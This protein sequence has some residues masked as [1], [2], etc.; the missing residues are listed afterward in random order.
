MSSK[1]SYKNIARVN[2]RRAKLVRKFRRHLSDLGF[3]RSKG[4]LS[5][6]GSGKDVI[7]GLHAEHRG[8]RIDASEQFIA[9][10]Y[11]KLKQYFASGADIDPKQ[12]KP[13]L[14]RIEADTWQSS[15]FRLASLTWSVPVS[16][17]FGRRMR[18]L[19]WDDH[20][21]KLIGLIA[22]GDPVFN[23]AVRDKLIGWTTKDRGKRLVNI[24]DAYVLGAIPPY[25]HLL[26]GKLV[27]SLVRT[28]EIYDDF[29]KAYGDTR[30]IIS[31][32]KKKARLLV[33]TT[34]SSLGRSSIYNRL[35]LG[36]QKYFT[37]IGFTGGWGHFHIPDG[38]F[39]E[40][41]AYLRDI[42]HSYADL[43]K[44]GEGPNWRLRTTRAALTALGYKE[45][46][47]RHGIQR[48]VYLCEMASNALKIL[49]TGNGRPNLTKLKTVEEV[50]TL[51]IHRWVVP[52]SERMPEYKTWSAADLKLLLSRKHPSLKAI[53]MK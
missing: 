15:L 53:S 5:F 28:R 27:A 42:G 24:L 2:L 8:D 45:D 16:N 30:G 35:K 50:S 19:V 46:I 9:E 33:V 13:R 22:I 14:E 7:R 6:E 20:N 11:D 29:A 43:H 26:G 44:Y 40:M 4:T 31:R 48:E 47:L 21:S 17:G 49:R 32:K 37:P 51:A 41:R 39:A 12:I 1:K 18:Y 3:Q 34:T 25:S 38:L 23:L 10:Q 52:R 36:E